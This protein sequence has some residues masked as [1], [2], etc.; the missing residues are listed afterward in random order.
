MHNQETISGMGDIPCQ[1]FFVMHEI[2]HDTIETSD[3]N[4]TNDT[5]DTNDMDLIGS[6]LR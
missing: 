5:S 2:T 4:D 1:T 3:T 6:I